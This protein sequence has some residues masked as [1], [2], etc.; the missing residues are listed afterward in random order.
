MMIFGSVT[1]SLIFFRVPA[2]V[3]IADLDFSF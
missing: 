3:I 1:Y 2:F